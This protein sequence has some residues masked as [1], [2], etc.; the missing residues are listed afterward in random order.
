MRLL[1]LEPSFVRHNPGPPETWSH[2]DTLAEA[3]GIYFMCPKCFADNGGPIGTH[4]V[5]CWFVGKVP[6]DVSP[7][8][9]RWVP[10]GG[11]DDLSFV[12]PSSAS[13]A[14][15]GGCNAHF[16]VMGGAIIPA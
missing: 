16:F 4:I 1:E 14:L 9:G 7:K 8:P 3:H 10:S 13:V 11:Y 5:V 15:S 2:V 6:D 12:G